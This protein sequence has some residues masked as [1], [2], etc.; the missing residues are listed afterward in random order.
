MSLSALLRNRYLPPSLVLIGLLV[1][2]LVYQ[3]AKNADQDRVHGDVAKV[4]GVQ[5]TSISSRIET[6]IA[7]LQGLSDLISLRP[8]MDQLAFRTCARHTMERQPTISTVLWLPATTKP[9]EHPQLRYSE[10]ALKTDAA[11]TLSEKLEQ[12]LTRARDSDQLVLS[13]L[14][15]APTP[16][17]PVPAIALVQPVRATSEATGATGQLVG[18]VVAFCQLDKL[19]EGPSLSTNNFDGEWLLL[20][21][22]ATDATR[23][24]LLYRAEDDATHKAQPP[25]AEELRI[26]W[27]HE[28]FLT[29][30]ERVWLLLFRPTS[31]A[32]DDASSSVPG[33]LL[34]AGLTITLMTAGFLR[35]YLQRDEL[36]ENSVA[37]RT[38]SLQDTQSQLEEDIRRREQTESLLRTSEQQLHSLMENSPGAIYV[39]DVDGCY[40]AVNRRFT[41]LH[42]RPREDFIGRS[43]FD[44]FAP[45]LAARVRKTDAQVMAGAEQLE[46]EESFQLADGT[47]VNLIHKFPLIDANS[48]VHGVCA[49]ATDITERKLA[50]AEVRESRR[51]LES[52]LGQLP[53][54]AFRFSNDGSLTPVYVSRGAAGLTGHTARDFL[55]KQI[56]LEELVHPDDRKRVRAAIAAA[57]RKRRSFEVEYRLID[58]VGREKWVLERGQ[59]IHDETGA[60]LFIEGLAIDITQRKDAE[61]EKLL[62]ERRLLEGQ[63]LESIGVLAGGIAHDFN[64]LLTGIIGNANLASLDLPPGSKISNNLR[65]IEIASQRAAELCQQMLAYAGKGRFI[66]QPVE[67]GAL[68]K[69]TVPL[70]QASISKR[71]KLRFD[72]YPDLPTVLSDPTQMRQIVMN[73]VINASEALA[74]RDGEIAITTNLVRPDS[75]W[76][77]GAALAPPDTN[78]EFVRLEVR[79]TGSGMSAETITKIFEPF[80]TTKFTGRGLGL[81]AVLGIIRSHR[82]GLIVRSV[83]GKGSIFA[84]F[85]PAGTSRPIETPISRGT[86]NTPWQRTG[87]ILVVDD[88]PHVLSVA[89]GMLTSSGMTVEIANDGYE[90][91]DF[92]RANPE[93][94]DLVLLD[95]TMPRLTGEETLRLLREIRPSVRVL[96]MSGYN[97]REVVDALPGRATLGFMQKPFNLQVL[98]ENLQFMLG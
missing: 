14:I 39:K 58:R 63:K 16:K 31:D 69:S 7:G 57:V 96:F 54:M 32:L 37:Q 98:R 84:L 5:L 68:V 20:D 42:G 10:P 91:L 18:Y 67:L 87:R 56:S 12:S 15:N 6:C 26:G 35:S 23:N 78:L 30:G 62:V 95:M 70:L 11:A 21:I 38:A 93:S 8:G 77:D 75:D 85:L 3:H 40:L 66:V 2:F 29:L 24:T 86:T 41:E 1:S 19:F 81:A 79:D 89:T 74:D 4:A 52:L 53:G 44:L 17:G 71:A 9:G 51:Q 82:G 34:T 47:H 45:D 43:D 80:F 22:T 88:E 72:L 46:T 13:G 65:Q 55:E 36:I 73:L 25:S 92:F 83:L 28:Q 27:H 49:I 61:S 59:G 60:L 48:A 33:L 76:F 50:E 97:R 94:F 90:A 64:N